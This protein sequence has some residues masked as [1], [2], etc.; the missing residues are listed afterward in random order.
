MVQSLR[1]S[2][3]HHK[4]RFPCCCSQLDVTL[5]V[6]RA[7]IKQAVAEQ[8]GEGTAISSCT[9]ISTT[10]ESLSHCDVISVECLSSQGATLNYRAKKKRFY[11]SPKDLFSFS[12]IIP[13]PKILVVLSVEC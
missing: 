10:V 2:N 12:F 13:Q 3:F 5:Q 9:C 8:R 11:M 4:K 7:E 6:D 1:Y